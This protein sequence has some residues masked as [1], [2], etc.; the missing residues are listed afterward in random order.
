MK[1]RRIAELLNCELRGPGDVE[2]SGVAGI[3]EAETTQLTFVSN[4][5]YIP[6]I[7]TT[8]AGAIILSPDAPSTSIPTLLC[9][10][11]YTA[12]AKTIELFY[13]APKPVPG[14]HPTATISPGV[15]MGDSPSIGANVVIGEGVR[16]GDNCTLYPN[17]IIYPFAEIGDDFVAHSN[18]VVR[19]YCKIGHRVILQDGAVIGADGFGFAPQKNG[20]YY[21]IVQ[22]GIVVLEDDVEIGANTCVDRATVGETR[23]GRGTK[24]DNLVQIGHGCRLG[25]DT[26]MAAQS[27]LAG[28]TRVGNHVFLGGQVGAAGHLT[29]GDGVVAIAQT[30]IARS[31]EAGKMISGSPEMDFGLWKKNYLLMLKLPELVQEIKQLKKEVE[32]LKQKLEAKSQ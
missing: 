23:V 13:R 2:I 31:V 27:G 32:E 11:P 28:S 21:K 8:R 25:E 30:G 10:D 6:K 15:S 19:E 16:L 29:I 18:S 24:L 9:P 3:E 5:K 14:I 17:V 22:S 26:A 12:F 20:G 1:L 4:A 7:K